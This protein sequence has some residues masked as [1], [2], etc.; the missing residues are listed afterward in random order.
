M[1]PSFTSLITKA[2]VLV[3][4]AIIIINAR[5]VKEITSAPSHARR[6]LDKAFQ[7]IWYR[8]FVWEA[9]L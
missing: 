6:I 9:S 5:S 4:I 3:L 8:N 1:A 2:F 7:G